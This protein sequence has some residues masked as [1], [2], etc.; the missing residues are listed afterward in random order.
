M[1]GKR[2]LWYLCLA[3]GGVI[4]LAV[5]YFA[6]R[7]PLD[8]ITVLF[9]II[10]APLICLIPVWVGRL[11]LDQKPE[12]QRVE[13]VA[14]LV[15]TG[16][17]A[18]L[19]SAIWLAVIYGDHWPGYKIPIDPVWGQVLAIA[20]G[21]ITFGVVINLLLKGLG[22]PMAVYLSRQLAV[23]WM[24]AW[25]RNPMVLAGFSCL[26]SVGLWLRSLYFIL[27]AFIIVLPVMA[28]FLK[29]FE[30]REL[31]IR[32]GDSYREYRAHTPFLW[33]QKPK[34]S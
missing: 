7:I 23:E 22:L 18:F 5:C 1:T 33:P 27:W 19:G 29:V 21:L 11:L 26:V 14:L 12:P 8:S 31:E 9:Y 30:E 6:L 15:H 3:A 20:T 25:T 2:P 28:I 16:I 34:P 4:I 10:L 32:F 13:W 24:Y 17:F